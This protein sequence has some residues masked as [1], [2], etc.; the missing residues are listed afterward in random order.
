M[1]FKDKKH[2]CIFQLLPHRQPFEPVHENQLPSLKSCSANTAPGV[3]CSSAVA[4]SSFGWHSATK[5]VI[6]FPPFGPSAPPLPASSQRLAGSPW[7]PSVPAANKA[8]AVPVLSAAF[9]SLNMLREGRGREEKYRLYI[10][11]SVRLFHQSQC[12]DRGLVF[13]PSLPIRR[14][15]EG[16]YEAMLSRII[17]VLFFMSY[18]PMVLIV[19]L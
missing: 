10:C 6:S 15:L 4:S 1:C 3:K 5:Y 9:Y 2:V 16:R 13:S 19:M 14:V 8:A 11:Q 17:N 18:T 7:T 12:L